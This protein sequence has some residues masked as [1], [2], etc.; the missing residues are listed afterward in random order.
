M[1]SILS[2]Q[3]FNPS[4][5]LSYMVHPLQL[6]K[7]LLLLST[8]VAQ[9]QHSAIVAFEHSDVFKFTSAVVTHCK[10]YLSGKMHQLPFVKSNFQSNEP[11]ELIHSYVCGPVPIVSINDFRYYLV[12]VDDFTKF[13]WVYLLK[14]KSDVFNIF[15]YFKATIE[16]QL[17]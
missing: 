11:L 4:F 9:E 1:V 13:T 15:K 6:L 3:S 8:S 2:T 5:L 16:N 10:H 14:L 12:F 17:C 7:L